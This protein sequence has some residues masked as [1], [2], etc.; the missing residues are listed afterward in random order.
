M[1][2]VLIRHARP[3]R[4][5]DAEVA[6]DPELTELGHRQAKALARWLSDDR[7]DALYTSPM[8]RARETSAPLE[9]MLGLEAE[10]IDGVKEYDAEARR[11]IPIED[12][13]ADKERWHR[14][15]AQESAED[16]TGFARTVVSSLEDL[17]GRHRGQRIAVVCHGGVINMWAAE[18]L[19]LKPDM[20]FEPYY[21]SVNR[22]M[23]ASSGE[24]SVASLN[25]VGHLRGTDP[26][27]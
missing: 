7:F 8:I 26:S 6:A 16:R 5:D 13:K 3:H 15:L 11:Y 17:I 22:F 14:F 4:I 9:E 24:R 27:V 21:T 12:L 19:G 1:E 2:I 20:F 18:V 23:A 25:E 10:V